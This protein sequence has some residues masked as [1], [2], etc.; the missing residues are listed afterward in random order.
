MKM[1]QKETILTAKDFIWSSLS[2]CIFLLE[3]LGKFLIYSNGEP[4]VE[5]IIKLNNFENHNTIEISYYTNSTYN[6][7]QRTYHHS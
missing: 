2:L 5:E 6:Y 7:G 3:N 4:L 1:K